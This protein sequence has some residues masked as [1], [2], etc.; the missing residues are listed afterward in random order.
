MCRVS[1]WSSQT[2]S[3]R[4]AKPA[5]GLTILADTEAPVQTNSAVSADRN[6]AASK[7][8]GSVRFAEHLQP[9]SPTGSFT[10]AV[11]IRAAPSVASLNDMLLS[12]FSNRSRC[13]VTD[14]APSMSNVMVHA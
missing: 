13:R 11:H 5:K 12:T 6:L 2:G 4:K 7:R 10:G 8:M 3:P 14:P 1:S 9:D